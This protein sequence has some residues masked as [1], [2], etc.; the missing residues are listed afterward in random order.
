MDRVLKAA[1]ASGS[2]N[3]SNRSLRREMRISILRLKFHL[4]VHF[5][6]AALYIWNTKVLFSCFLVYDLRY[7]EVPDEV[8]K[9]MD[10]V[11]GDEK[12]WEVITCEFAA[13]L[14]LRPNYIVSAIDWSHGVI[15][16][17]GAAEADSSS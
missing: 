1:R 8:Y 12:W 5:Y 6:F 14:L 9:I 4:V 16:D 17:C 11:G 13:L 7:R 15:T 10:A 2:L 3:L